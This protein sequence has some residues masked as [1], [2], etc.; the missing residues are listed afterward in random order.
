[1]SR[2][3]DNCKKIIFG[4]ETSFFLQ[5]EMQANTTFMKQHLYLMTRLTR[6]LALVLPI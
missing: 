4:G 5:Q 1:M 6:V 3:E 2:M